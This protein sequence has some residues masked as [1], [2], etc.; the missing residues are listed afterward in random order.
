MK[1]SLLMC[2]VLIFFSL[3][4]NAQSDM[5]R[6]NQLGYHPKAVKQF[7]VASP[8]TSVNFKVVRD[9]SPVFDGMLGDVQEWQMAGEAVRIGEFTAVEAEGTYS[10]Q[11]E[12]EEASHSFTIS[13]SVFEDLLPA[14]IRAYYYL[15]SGTPLPEK[16]AGKWHRNAGHPDVK[17]PYHRSLQRKG[18]IDSPKGWYDAG[19]YG[20]YTV[21][22]AFTA[23]QLL[24]VH[25]RF[26][27]VFPDGSLN[28]PESGNGISDL[29][30]EVKYETDWLLTMQDVD[31]GLFHK[32]TCNRFVGMVLPEEAHCQRFMMA[33]G[34][35]GTLDF[36]AVMAKMYRAYKAIDKA[37]AEQCLTA[38]KEAWTWAK[39]HPKV[40]F[41]NPKRVITGE[42]GDT[43]FLEEWFWASAELYGA[44]QEGE[45][46]EFIKNQD[47]QFEYSYGDG[48]R[49]F[50]KYLGIFTLLDANSQIPES[51]REKFENG[52]VSL[53]DGLLEKANTLDYQQAVDSYQWGSNSDIQNT[54][55]VMAEAYRLEPKEVYVW[56]VQSALDYLLGK[57][58]MAHSFITGFGSKSPMQ[59]HHRPSA[60]DGIEAPVPGYVVGGPNF[61][62]QDR[63]EVTYPEEVTP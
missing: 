14:S 41:K 32:L 59:I 7:V 13:Q 15:R 18:A 11:I 52:I 1:A 62:R 3:S 63:N 19:D 48:W 46:L 61:D 6:I 56:G 42:Y 27:E 10:I 24:M 5:I 54:A 57:N 53:A 43:D 58:A 35:A 4:C 34:T 51:L 17:V 9:G 23:G 16:H 37:Y 31:G 2:S 8:N 21:N 29:L 25:E 40:E 49:K 30:D 55:V 26:P 22:G 20:K 60:G 47:I 28:I 44:T 38:A 12:G 33:K 50:M 36:A 45:Y 39:I